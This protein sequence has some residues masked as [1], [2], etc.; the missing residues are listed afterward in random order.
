MDNAFTFYR[1]IVG[2]GLMSPAARILGFGL[3]SYARA[4]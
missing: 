3:A 1:Q 4:F 2:A